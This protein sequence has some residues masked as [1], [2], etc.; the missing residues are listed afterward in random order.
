MTDK[1]HSST[2]AGGITIASFAG[3]CIQVATDL[4][5]LIILAVVLIAGDF[6][7]GW[8]EC[9]M[10]RDEAKTDAEKEKYEWHNSRAVRRTLNKI[11]DYTSYMLIGVV[12]GLALTEPWGICDHTTAAMAGMVFGCLCEVSS[13]FGHVAYVKGIRIKIDIKRMAVAIIRRKSEELA[14]VLDEGIEYVDDDTRKHHAKHP[15]IYG[16]R[17]MQ[18]DDYGMD[19]RHYEDDDT[20]HCGDDVNEESDDEEQKEG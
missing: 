15:K 19:A 10:H 4:R 3:E 2:A 1:L 16:E 9:K 13:I 11:V 8:R 7:W 20:H 17:P 5:W 6:W 12:F 18:M 14:E